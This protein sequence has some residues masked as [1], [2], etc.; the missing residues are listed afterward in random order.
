MIGLAPARHRGHSALVLKRAEMPPGSSSRLGFWIGVG[1]T[2]V[3]LAW[4]IGFLSGLSVGAESRF[5]TDADRPVFDAGPFGQY[6]RIDYPSL[7][8][9]KVDA[10]GW[11]FLATLVGTVLLTIVTAM[12]GIRRGGAVISNVGVAVL[13]ATSLVVL[14][15]TQLSD[16]AF[17]T[18][19]RQAAGLAVLA[20]LTLLAAL[21]LH[22]WAR[23]TRT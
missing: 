3:H 11:L 4:V 19:T 1:W 7:F 13:G 10:V 6:A 5:C 16:G 22:W 15:T 18:G 21:A 8:S 14:W 12:F 20:A 9:A 2:L 23:V 17:C